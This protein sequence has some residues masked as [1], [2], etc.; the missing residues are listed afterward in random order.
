MIKK[1]SRNLIQS[2]DTK[3]DKNTT[4]HLA[5]IEMKSFTMAGT[6]FLYEISSSNEDKSDREKIPPKL[7]IEILDGSG[8]CA[9]WRSFLSTLVF[10]FREHALT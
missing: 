5:T 1:R 8:V 7:S 4:A 6:V 9:V 3:F 2:L 10:L